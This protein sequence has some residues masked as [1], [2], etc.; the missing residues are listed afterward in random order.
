M[1]SNSP[2]DFSAPASAAPLPPVEMT[3]GITV[4]S[5]GPEGPPTTGNLRHPC[6]SGFSR[7]RKDRR[8]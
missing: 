7:D 5:V 4:S 3:V 8:A 1:G 6:G 2:G